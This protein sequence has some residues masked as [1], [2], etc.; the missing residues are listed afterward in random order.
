MAGR[1]QL[2][3]T[4]ERQ[5]AAERSRHTVRRLRMLVK[6]YGQFGPVRSYFGVAPSRRRPPLLARLL[7]R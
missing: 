7:R 6:V 5:D 2:V 3:Q 4:D 1:K